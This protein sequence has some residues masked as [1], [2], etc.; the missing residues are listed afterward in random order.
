MRGKKQVGNP[1]QLFR[2][3]N[4]TNMFTHKQ[5]FFVDMYVRVR[6]FLKSDGLIYASW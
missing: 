3:V 6:K 4:C 1:A 2:H 5:I